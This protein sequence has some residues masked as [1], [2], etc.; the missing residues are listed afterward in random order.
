M[1][2]IQAIE[3]VFFKNCVTYVHLRGRSTKVLFDDK[4]IL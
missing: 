2:E 4:S 1:L 3:T